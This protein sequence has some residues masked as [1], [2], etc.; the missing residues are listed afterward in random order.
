[1]PVLPE[2]TK[3]VIRRPALSAVTEVASAARAMSPPMAW[4]ATA[5]GTHSK[6]TPYT[7]KAYDLIIADGLESA[8]P[9]KQEAE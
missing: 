5:A 4:E 3:T 9:P 7:I 8:I 1:M 6:S 2:H